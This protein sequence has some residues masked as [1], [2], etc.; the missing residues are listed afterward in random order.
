[1]GSA[2]EEFT[3]EW[4]IPSPTSLSTVVLLHFVFLVQWNTRRRRKSITA[5]YRTVIEKK[6]FHRLWCALLSH[7]AP[8]SSLIEHCACLRIQSTADNDSHRIAVDMGDSD[9]P[10]QNQDIYQSIMSSA[11]AVFNSLR[12]MV[13]RIDSW[14]TTASLGAAPLLI[15]NCHIVWSCRALEEEYNE[16]FQSNWNYERILL[17]W[18]FLAYLTELALYRLLIRRLDEILPRSSD[19]QGDSLT[20]MRNKLLY[21]SISTPTALTAAMLLVYHLQYPFISPQIFPVLGNPSF[22]SRF[23]SFSYFLCVLILTILS[24]QSHSITAIT[25]GG[26]IGLIW[27]YTGFLVQ[28]YWNI[29]LSFAFCLFTIISARVDRRFGKDLIPCIDHVAMNNNGDILVQNEHGQWVPW[30]KEE[31]FMESEENDVSSV[32]SNLSGELEAFPPSDDEEIYGSRL[33][34]EDDLESPSVLG[35]W[36]R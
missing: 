13:F 20:S 23:P 14:M 1:M 9:V 2:V 7:P 35:A 3:I 25:M 16:P 22:L 31:E 33:Q 4:K 30:G 36:C 6:R 17:T 5:N 18:G 19:F 21:R 10:Q 26:F 32:S 27:W 29:P 11:W 8:S 34:E 24:Y 28:P 12:E 15:Y